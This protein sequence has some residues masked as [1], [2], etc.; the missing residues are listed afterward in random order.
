MSLLKIWPDYSAGKTARHAD[1]EGVVGAL[2]TVTAATYSASITVDAS[3][4]TYVQIVATDTSA[5]TINNPT[6]ARAGMSLVFDILNSSGGTLGTPT[7]DTLF[8][9]A[10]TLTKPANT[11]RKTISFYFDGSAWIEESRA[12]ADI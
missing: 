5:F 9:L 1:V 8:K 7:W 4:Q 2:T 12:A 3:A 10:G 11:K 6:N